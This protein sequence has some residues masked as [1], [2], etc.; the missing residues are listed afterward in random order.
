MSGRVATCIVLLGA[1][2]GVDP[3]LELAFGDVEPQCVTS[4][5]CLST[6]TTE[7]Q[8]AGIR[9]IHKRVPGAAILS[10][11][12]LMDGGARRW[13]FNV[14][15]AEAMVLRLVS[16]WGSERFRQTPF[17]AELARIGARFIAGQGLDFAH[18]S[19]AAPATYFDRAW[20]LL[21]DTIQ[22]PPIRDLSEETREHLEQVHVQ[23][24]RSVYATPLSAASATAWG[25]VYGD[26]PYRML[27]ETLSQIDQLDPRDLSYAA[28]EMWRKD[29]LTVVVV[30][31][32]DVER[33]QQRV[34]A[35]FAHL[36]AGDQDELP[37]LPEPTPSEHR[38]QVLDFPDAPGWH[39]Q[40]YFPAPSPAHESYLALRLGI[41]ALDRR[42]FDELRTTRSLVYTVG[43]EVGE[44][45][46]NYGHLWL[47][48]DRPREA[49][50][51][52]HRVLDGWRSSGISAHELAAARAQHLAEFHEQ[53][54][55]AGGISWTLAGWQLTGGGW[56]LADEQIDRLERVNA[57]EVNAALLRCLENVRYAAAGAGEPLTAEMLLGN[58]D[59]G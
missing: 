40:A 21:A 44:L 57:A 43:A 34:D 35:A 33:V 31:D 25:M 47:S 10:A 14:A 56:T 28:S 41:S 50:S 52:F 2:C 17:E 26:H 4:A 27:E 5:S 1:A 15:H 59:A 19:I 51:A 37:P 30:G 42:L 3:P 6:N 46:S 16:W 32:V 11:R 53:N 58:A 20:R 8:V 24:L 48:T 12:V 36:L 55:T 22:A 7:R 54:A 45:R 39:V 9:V 29:R 49:L 18:V 23:D 13:T 38:A